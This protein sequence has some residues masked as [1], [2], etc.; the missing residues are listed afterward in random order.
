M[1]TGVVLRIVLLVA[2]FI[3]L[4]LPT[5]WAI[6]HIAYRSFPSLK[7]K[8]LWFAVVTLLP[9]IGAF[10]YIAVGRRQAMKEAEEKEEQVEADG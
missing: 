5:V 9:P 6:R 4:F 1:D 3:L 2:V 7:A 10:V 8:A